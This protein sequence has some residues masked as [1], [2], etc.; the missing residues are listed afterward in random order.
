MTTA[1]ADSGTDCT[2]PV[3]LQGVDGATPCTALRA[4]TEGQ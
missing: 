4:A 3:R 1:I 2:L